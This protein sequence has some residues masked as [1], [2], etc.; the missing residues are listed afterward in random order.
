MNLFIK[1]VRHL[2]DRIYHRRYRTGGS[3]ALL[4]LLHFL[5][6]T[7]QF[8]PLTESHLLCIF[9][10]IHYQSFY[11]TF[12][13]FN[14]LRHLFFQSCQSA[15]HRLVL[16]LYGNVNTLFSLFVS[17]HQ[18]CHTVHEQNIR[19]LFRRRRRILFPTQDKKYRRGQK[20]HSRSTCHPN[21]I[22]KYRQRHSGKKHRHDK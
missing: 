20:H 16:L 4:G 1:S 11:G 14:Q 3:A 10:I 2:S 19:G 9:L 12:L 13:C 21:I 5:T 8:F 22:L 18:L 15:F 7:S 6:Q 17:P